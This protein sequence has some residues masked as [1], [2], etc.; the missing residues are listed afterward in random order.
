MFPKKLVELVPPTYNDSD[1]HVEGI[2][3]LD[4]IIL[5]HMVNMEEKDLKND[6]Q[7]DLENTIGSRDVMRFVKYVFYCKHIVTII[8]A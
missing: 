6:R 1:A 8:I 7:A 5:I 3:W 2:N 4:S